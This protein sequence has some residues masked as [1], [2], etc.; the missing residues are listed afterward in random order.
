[1]RSTVCEQLLALLLDDARA[2]GLAEQADVAAER[3]LAVGA[4]RVCH[5]AIEPGTL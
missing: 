4:G 5:P 1:M 2:E 3:R